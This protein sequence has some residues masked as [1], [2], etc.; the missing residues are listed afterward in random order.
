MGSL[1]VKWMKRSSPLPTSMTS[2]DCW[3]SK[4]EKI[5]R[6]IIKKREIG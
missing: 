2:R 4:C 5:M 1:P 6:A 3:A